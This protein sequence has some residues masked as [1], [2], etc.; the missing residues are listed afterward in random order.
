MEDIWN[1]LGFD[2]SFFDIFNNILSKLDKMFFKSK[3]FS[4][5]VFKSRDLCELSS[6]LF[7][8]Q[9]LKEF[10]RKVYIFE[11]LWNQREIFYFFS[12]IYGE[13]YLLGK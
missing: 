12:I 8:C 7:Y 6:F 4:I 1:Q 9:E 2:F 5:L 13:E 3:E 10:L 11:S